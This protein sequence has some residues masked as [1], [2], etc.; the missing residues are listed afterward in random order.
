MVCYGAMGKQ[1]Y[2]MCYVAKRESNYVYDVLGG[3]GKSDILLCVMGPCEADMNLM[4]YGANGRRYC[5]ILYEY[6]CI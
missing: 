3:Q 5:D 1:I 2:L 6:I 4:C